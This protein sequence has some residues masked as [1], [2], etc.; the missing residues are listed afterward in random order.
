VIRGE[1]VESEPSPSKYILEASVVWHPWRNESGIVQRATA[2]TP[3]GLFKALR[4]AAIDAQ[5]RLRD[6]L[7]HEIPA[8]FE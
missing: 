4:I 1:T 5:E 7:K 6:S 3:K 8:Q 2:S